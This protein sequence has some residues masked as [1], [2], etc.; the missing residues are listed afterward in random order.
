MSQLR[1][2]SIK[3]FNN[4]IGRCLSFE[5]IQKIMNTYYNIFII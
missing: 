3:R 4:K 2:L 5:D 1:T